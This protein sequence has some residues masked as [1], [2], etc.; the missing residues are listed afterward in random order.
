M[1]NNIQLHR[2]IN[3]YAQKLGVSRVTLNKYIKLQF[4]V[5]VSEM[6]D[7]YFLFEI[8]S[9]LLYSQFSIKEIADKFAFSEP[10]HLVSVPKI[11][12]V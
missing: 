8:K 10:N 2:D 5:T 4:G 6:I 12:T 7:E 3:F 1:V 9:L 11:R